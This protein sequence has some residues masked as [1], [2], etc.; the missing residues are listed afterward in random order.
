MSD[1]MAVTHHYADADWTLRRLCLKMETVV[2]GVR[3]GHLFVQ[4][5]THIHTHTHSQTCKYAQHL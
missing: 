5:L 3:G 1:C 2:K 4:L